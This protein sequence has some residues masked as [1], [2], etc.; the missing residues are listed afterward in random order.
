M[1]SVSSS[2]TEVDMEDLRQKMEQLTQDVLEIQAFR[3][4][5]NFSSSR[6]K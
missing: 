2:A 6:I 3:D 5:R 1:Q 4:P